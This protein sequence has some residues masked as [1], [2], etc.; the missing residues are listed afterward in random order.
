M[1]SNAEPLAL[2]ENQPD[3][4]PSHLQFPVVGIGA[5]AGGLPAL[6]KLFEH[7][8]ATQDMAFVVIL[9]LS[10]THPSSAAEIL[11]RATRMPVIQVTRAPTSNAATC[12]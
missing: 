9:H 8:P 6:L 11:Q 10:P 1:T 12:T 4:A 5:S 3:L 2:P 7:M